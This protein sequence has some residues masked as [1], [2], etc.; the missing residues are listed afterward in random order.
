MSLPSALD[1]ILVDEGMEPYFLPKI[2][3]AIASAGLN[4]AL[5]STL[6]AWGFKDGIIK[7]NGL[8][9]EQTRTILNTLDP[10]QQKLIE[11]ETGVLISDVHKVLDLIETKNNN[12]SVSSEVKSIIEKVDPFGTKSN[13]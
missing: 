11:K 8:N 3:R 7:S 4:D 2:K 1:L 12:P 5:K 10:D 6:K 9:I 13:K